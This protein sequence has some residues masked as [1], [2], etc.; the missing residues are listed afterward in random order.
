MR[1]DLGQSY[2]D[3][4]GD[5]LYEEGALGQGQAEDHGQAEGQ[6]SLTYV[7]LI[8][9]QGRPIIRIDAALL[10]ADR[11]VLILG[12]ERRLDHPE[13]MRILE[14]ALNSTA[15]V[16]LGDQTEEAFD[17]RKLEHHRDGVRVEI[18][19]ALV[20]AKRRPKDHVRVAPVLRRRESKHRC[21]QIAKQ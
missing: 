13:K 18:L 8:C 20:L 12:I 2:V 16:V 6:G 4:V 9:T 3:N 14:L 15:E 21:R 10:V 1:L 17:I 5:D 11:H 7:P 19:A